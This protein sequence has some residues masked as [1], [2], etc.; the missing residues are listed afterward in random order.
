MSVLL[1][2]SE[3]SVKLMTIH[4]SKGLEFPVVILP[5]LDFSTGIYNSSKFIVEVNDDILYTTLKKE[6]PIKEIREKHA[7]ESNQIITDKVNLCYVAF[8]RA[9]ERLYGFNYF[10]ST[11]LGSIIH[12]TLEKLNY[13]LKNEKI[14]VEIGV[15]EE[16]PKAYKE[17][18]KSDY[19]EPKIIGDKLWFPDIAIRQDELSN[20]L[21]EEQ[22]FGNAFH[23]LMANC[24]QARDINDKLD[25]LIYQDLIPS[26]YRQKLIEKTKITF[27]KLEQKQILS[28]VSVILNEKSIIASDDSIKRPDKIILKESETI[29]IDFK[30]G[31]EKAKDEKQLLEYSEYLKKMNLP[32]VKGY[33][34]YALT[35]ELKEISC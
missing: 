18:I 23:L 8:T 30:T 11:S 10:K 22:Q 26:N 24:N 6:H 35:E 2:E 27:E 25:Q 12:S 1:P 29:V 31:T 14:T 32:K 13:G 5:K 20:E 16:N 4:K 34:Y 21:S 7:N 3:N 33:L 9:R 15:E 19:F 17:K 28:D